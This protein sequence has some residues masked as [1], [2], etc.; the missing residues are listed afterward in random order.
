M[1][2]ADAGADGW[3]NPMAK[4]PAKSIT[5][6]ITAIERTRDAIQH[7]GEEGRAKLQGIQVDPTL[8]GLPRNA[9]N[10]FDEKAWDALS[11]PDQQADRAR[12]VQVRDALALLVE[13][14]PPESGH[15]MHD[16]YAS[17]PAVITFLVVGILAM[18][19]LLV[20]VHH[21][22]SDATS[23]DPT[24]RIHAAVEAQEEAAKAQ[25]AVAKAKELVKPQGSDAGAPGSAERLLADRLKQ[26]AEKA[27]QDV[28]EKADRARA[29]IEAIGSVRAAEPA[30]LRMVMLLGALGGVLHFLG[31]FVMFVGNRRLKRSWLPYYVVMPFTG[32]GLAAIVYMLL[33]VG[34]L[35]P[36]DG[37]G[38]PTGISNLNLMAVYAFA[39]MAGL[40]SRAATDKLGEVFATIFRTG[41]PPSKDPVGQSGGKGQ[42]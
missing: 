1:G 16:A 42:T 13:D 25:E 38:A 12:L 9:A 40:F 37:T 31:S 10:A 41:T 2:L 22:W 21:F 15:V 29:A 19:G 34:I 36:T 39:T 27:Q 3:R 18:V 14:G 17:H 4:I 5:D 23:S 6:L 20:A 24:A 8:N 32:A 33:R 7:A 26:E 35:S 28:K 11:E 30:V